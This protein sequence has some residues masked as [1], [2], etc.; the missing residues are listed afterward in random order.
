MLAVAV[1]VAAA[2]AVLIPGAASASPPHIGS[3]VALGDSYAAGGGAPPY[4]DPTCLRSNNSYPALLAA[5]KHVKS[6]Q[7]N[8]CSVA[9]TQDVLTSQLTGLNRNTDL[10]TITIGGNDLNFTPGIGA[11][12]QGTDA[13]C[14]AIVATAEKVTKTELP[15]RL[16]TVYRTVRARAPHASVVVAGYARFFETTAECPAVPPA[17]LVKRRAINGAV[18]T[19][20]RTIALAAVR[21][22]FRFADVRPEFAGHGLCGPNP[23]LTGLTDPTPFHPTATGYRAGYLPAVLFR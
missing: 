2:A 13:D 1:A 7:F 10:V 18:D 23:W 3:Y 6:F 17:S 12:M 11:C 5:A 22:G 20:D 15:G 19:L 8:A 9:A 16:A 14:Q 4:T 21:A